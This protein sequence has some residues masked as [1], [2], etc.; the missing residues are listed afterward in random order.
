[1][2]TRIMCLLLAITL[3]S[4]TFVLGAGPAKPVPA[5]ADDGGCSCC[6][7]GQIPEPPIEEANKAV[8][9]ALASKEVHAWRASIREDGFHFDVGQRAIV[10]LGGDESHHFYRVAFLPDPLPPEEVA[11]VVV[12]VDTVAEA[13]LG[14][15]RVD[16]SADTGDSRTIT[17]HLTNGDVQEFPYQGN[18]SNINWGC[19][20]DCMLLLAPEVFYFCCLTTSCVGGN[21]P[22]CALCLLCTGYAGALCAIACP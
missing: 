16:I 22:G 14:T 20:R 9:L 11:G 7:N 6:E 13:V 17:I 18:Y 4:S 10:F 2:K 12:V 15:A 8:A 19:W 3:A 1:M 21:L 5:L